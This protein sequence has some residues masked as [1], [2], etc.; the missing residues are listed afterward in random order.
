MAIGFHTVP[1]WIVRAVS[2]LWTVGPGAGL[3]ETI[4]S[5]NGSLSP[6]S[7]AAASQEPIS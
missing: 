3:T 7:T 4:Q 6:Q 2:R 1:L 5:A